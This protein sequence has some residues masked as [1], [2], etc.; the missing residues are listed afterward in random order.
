MGSTGMKVRSM[1]SSERPSVRPEAM[2]LQLDLGRWLIREARPT[3]DPALIVAGFCERLVAGGVQLLR[4]RIGQAVKNPL[5]AAWGV[6]WTRSGGAELYTVERR[7]LETTAWEGSP[8]QT[9]VT[10]EKSVRQRLIGVDLSQA[11]SVYREAVAMGGTDYLALPVRYGDG[12]RQA[13]S[14]I[15]DAPDGFADEA[16][17][18]IDELM[19]ALAAA[20]EPIAMRRSIA[21]LLRAY[22]GHGPADGVSA[23]QFRRGDRVTIDA[24]ILLTDLRGFT[25]LA[26]SVEPEIV[27]DKLSVY[28]D[29]VVEAVQARGGDVLKFVGDAVL[30]VWPIV[31]AARA[32]EACQAAMNAA[33]AA[34]A[35]LAEKDPSLRFVA[36]LH[37]GTVDYGNIGSPD[38]LDF[39]IIGPAVNLASRMETLAKQLNEPLVASRTFADIADAGGASLGRHTLRD[40]DEPVELVRPDGTARPGLL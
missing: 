5:L 7:V 6:I 12:S 4:A 2:A 25:L 14:F 21:S 18:L 39:T 3:N 33:A 20:L 16:L 34:R 17:W 9:V 32:G 27:L 35:R 37:R 22:L 1:P 15:T 29:A 23:G 30:A 8:F 40:I 28:F 26:Q 19:A 10:Q 38:R 31:D 24:A 36:V 13:W 11:H